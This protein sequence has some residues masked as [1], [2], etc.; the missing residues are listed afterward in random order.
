MKRILINLTNHPS[1]KWSIE[2]IEA[3]NNY[4][5]I[6]DIPFP[7]VDEK[8]DEQYIKDLVK[9]YFNKVLIYKSDCN[10]TVHIMGE[11]TFTF[12]LIKLL[13]EQGIKC[14]SSTTK[15]IVIDEGDG[16]KEKVIFEFERFREYI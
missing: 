15:R 7:V 4:G 13:Q 5:S 16:V 2:Q 1:N 9:E 8:G 3:A 14:I 10:I 12:A 6:I 11:M